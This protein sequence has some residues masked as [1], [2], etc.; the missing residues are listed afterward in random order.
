M[1]EQSSAAEYRVAAKPTHAGEVLM[2]HC[3]LCQSAASQPIVSPILEQIL[4]LCR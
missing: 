3:K 1:D 4:V 2:M